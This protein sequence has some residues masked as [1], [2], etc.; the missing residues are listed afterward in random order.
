YCR[1]P[2][3][4]G[5]QTWLTA[6][7]QLRRTRM[8]NAADGDFYHLEE[9]LDDAGRDAVRRTREF[10]TKE[11]E[12]VINQLWTREEFPHELIPAFARLGISGLAY[13]GFGC[14]GGGPLLDGMIAMELARVDPSI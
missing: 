6:I 13:D 12:P 1:W 2:P 3:S 10:M 4:A 5:R 7:S 9:L 8:T 11:I 14:P